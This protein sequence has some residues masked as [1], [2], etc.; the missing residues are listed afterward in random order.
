MTF[1]MITPICHPSPKDNPPNQNPHAHNQSIIN[2]NDQASLI[3]PPKYRRPN[4]QE[5]SSISTGKQQRI[6]Q[7]PSK[8]CSASK[9]SNRKNPKPCKKIP[10]CKTCHSMW[11][12]TMTKTLSSP[13]SVLI[14]ADQSHEEDQPMIKKKHNQSLF[15]GGWCLR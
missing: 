2:L 15:L 11:R 12:G 1:S 5:D 13:T 4:Q 6:N 10:Q 8:S 14:C 7:L 3:Q 9:N